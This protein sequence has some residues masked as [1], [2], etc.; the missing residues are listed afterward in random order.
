MNPTGVL[1]VYYDGLCPLCSREMVHYRK[2]EGS[3]NLNFVDITAPSFLAE[4]EGLDPLKVHQVMHVKT[5]EGEVRTGVDAFIEIWKIL[6]KYRGW[7]G[8]AQSAVIKPFLNFGYQIFAAIR[9][10]LPRKTRECEQSPYC[11]LRRPQ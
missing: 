7:V 11:D 9:P 1:S 2:Q 4:R 10:Y 5:P 6:P 8:W 3:Q